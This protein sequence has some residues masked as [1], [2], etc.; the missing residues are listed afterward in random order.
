MSPCAELNCTT[1]PFVLATTD[2]AGNGA[3]AAFLAS[4]LLTTLAIIWGYL[5]DSLPEWYLNETDK[6]IVSS[7]QSWLA[8]QRINRYALS[9]W[10]KLQ[11]CT[12]KAFGKKPGPKRKMS[13]EERQEAVTRFILVLS[14][15]QLATGL[16]ILIAGVVN[17][18]TLSVYEFQIVFA[19]AWFSSTTHLATLD[20]LRHYFLTHHV[21]RNC[22]VF[23]ML[24]LL[25]L[26][27]YT[28]VMSMASI[29]ETIP[30][31]CTFEYFGDQGVEDG[32]GLSVWL[33]VQAAVTLAYLLW[34]YVVRIWA[35]YKRA[36]GRPT[37][38]ERVIF[39][40]KARGLRKK[41]RP[42]TEVRERILSEAVLELR[43]RKRREELERIEA[44][45]GLWRRF[46]IVHRA[47]RLYS[48]SFLAHGPLLMF[49]IAYGFTQLY[50]SRWHPN[51][52]VRVESS[53]SFGQITSLFLLV[54]PIL[55]AAE[56]YYE[57][58]D[59][60]PHERPIELHTL[61]P[62]DL[63]QDPSS[64]CSSAISPPG[65]TTQTT[66]APLDTIAL[67]YTNRL[68]QLRT[69]FHAELKLLST[70]PLSP[71]TLPLPL[72]PSPS[73]HT[74]STITHHK[75]LLLSR[76]DTLQAIERRLTPTIRF[77][78]L[79]F[80]LCSVACIA[81]GI[82]L[83]VQS[84]SAGYTVASILLLAMHAVYSAVGSWA[85]SRD[86]RGWG[87]W[88]EGD[89]RRLVAEGMGRGGKGKS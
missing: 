33:I 63:P 80:A 88:K 29:D 38:L 4:A 54:L 24:F 61:Q 39:E 85:G 49:M 43:S 8:S 83:N 79:E 34:N 73:H 36:D 65:K 57:V 47:S 2:I 53:F 25:L 17:Q 60:V 77:S 59:G 71:H 45:R 66:T 74:T 42:S 32:S 55:A 81:L 13:R 48:E 3:L 52:D 21:V 35:S 46:L 86:A 22:R 27:S 75:S 12:L 89:Y 5:S 51:I 15:Q 50:S 72:S 26:L 10:S 18:C 9:L 62:I 78:L 82:V 84:S 56:I 1:R 76:L 20:C 16:A 68:P 30:L 11:H 37:V 31:A 87:R 64:S 58:K 7:F 14:D 40:R 67:S 70:N 19:L 6:H 28:L 23:G 41:Y 69:F 44:S